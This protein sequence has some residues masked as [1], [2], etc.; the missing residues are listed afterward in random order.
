ML[1]NKRSAGVTPEVNLR[2]PLCA[3]DEVHK[4][5]V[6][7]IFKKRKKG[8]I[9]SESIVNHIYLAY[10]ESENYLICS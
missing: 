5:V 8:K 4:Q 10:L 2:N 3:V 1:A 7:C 9:Y 6:H